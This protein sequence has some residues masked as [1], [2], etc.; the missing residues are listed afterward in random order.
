MV[1]S[2][3]QLSEGQ[4]L[5][6]GCSLSRHALLWMLTSETLARHLSGAIVLALS[7]SQ[8]ISVMATDSTLL[9][10]WPS[11]INWTKLPPPPQTSWQH[12]LP[13]INR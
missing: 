3:E 5:M 8:S 10:L 4:V 1:D 6:T 12:P 11:H 2:R 13:S 9:C 7:Y